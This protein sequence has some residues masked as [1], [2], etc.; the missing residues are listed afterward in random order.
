MMRL[1]LAME[2]GA[3]IDADDV[4]KDVVGRSILTR[5]EHLEGQGREPTDWERYQLAGAIQ[6]LAIGWYAHA[7]TCVALS[8]V[9]E[10]EVSPTFTGV[11]HPELAHLD[12][13]RLRQALA[14]AGGMPP[15]NFWQQF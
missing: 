10:G 4:K 2:W 9:P 15:F 5:I 12:T 11:R 8:K 1:L 14:H 3:M 7:Q 13:A 6:S